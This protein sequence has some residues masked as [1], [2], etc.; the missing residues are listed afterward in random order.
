MER[1]QAVEHLEQ[2][3]ADG[4]DVGLVAIVTLLDHLRGHVQGRAADGTILLI[5]LVQS[6][7]E[8]EVCDLNAEVRLHKVHVLEESSLQALAHV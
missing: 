4:P 1:C 5:E 3:D 8:A 2:D 7:G 6:F